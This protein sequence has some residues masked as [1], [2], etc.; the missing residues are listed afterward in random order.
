MRLT[1]PP[2]ELGLRGKGCLMKTNLFR[3][4]IQ[5]AIFLCLLTTRPAGAVGYNLTLGAQGSG[6][7]TPDNVNNPHPPGVVITIT[8][9]ANAGWYFANWS[10]DT[11]GSVNPLAVT[12]NSNLSI[13]GNFLAFPTYALTLVTNGQ[14]TIALS[15]TGGI[16]LSNTVV[17]ATA[18]PATGWVF[19]GWSGGTNTSANPVALTVQTNVGLTGTFAQLPAFDAQP[20]SVTN[21]SGST[22]NYSA[23]AV[24]NAPLRYQWFFSGGSLTTAATNTTLAL[25]NVA[26]GQAGNYW[27]VATN[28]YGS[29]TS[30]VA[31]LTLTNGSTNAVNSPD[32]ASLRAAIKIGGWVSLGFNGTVTIT[33]TINIT[34]NVILDGSA[35]AATISGGNAVRL[36]TVASGVTFALTNVTLANGSCIV[37]SGTPGTA[38]DAGAIYNN[39]GTVMLVGCTLTNNSAQSLI[40]GGLARGGVIFNNGGS[41]SLFQSAISN[42]AAIGGGPNSLVAYVTV[43]TSLGGAFFN[44]NGSML[45][46]GCNVSSNLSKSVCET[47][48]YY[49]GTGLAMGGG[50][51]QASGTMTIAGSIVS[52]NQALGGIGV[53]SSAGSASPAYGGACA[54][55]GSLTIDHSQFVANTAKGGDHGYHNSGASGF[56][57]AVYS[58]A[59]M[60]AS[61][62]SFFGNQTFSGSSSDPHA[63]GLINSYGGGIYNAGTA[64]LSRCLVCSNYVQGGMLIPYAFGVATSFDGL[65]GGIF[66]VSQMSATNCTIALNSAVGGSFPAG[67]GVCTSG[68]A[69]GGGV[70]NNTNATFIGMNLTIASNSCLSPTGVN[71][72]NSLAAGCQTANTSGTLRLHN[73]LLAYGGING[74][75]YGSITDDGYNICSDATGHLLSGA[76]YNNTDPQVAPVANYGG[77]TLSM[78]LLPTSPA[79]DFGDSAG[80]PSADQRGYARPFGAGPDMGA[81]EYGAEPPA[82]IGLMIGAGN[83]QLSYTSWTPGSYR[84]QASTNLTTWTDLI[85][86]GPFANPTYQSQTI[87]MQGFSHRYFRLLVQ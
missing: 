2:P 78:A 55:I 5:F 52:M 63:V 77:P 49:Y 37:T 47:D 50:I 14:G 34:N 73:S 61:D 10:G 53:F 86:N 36:F 42:N 67:N 70:F 68:N 12:M 22:V 11:N 87:G 40:F 16:Y 43:G 76:S 25:T 21:K 51:F 66:N 8:A 69:L 59:A 58:T 44:T 4:G 46:S 9:A 6:T 19:S 75:A 24:G 64:V 26:S 71:L 79:I 85:T 39:G 84:L 80:L 57:G 18:T 62:S 74:N 38:A 17:T 31:S 65:G 15:P 1:N 54:T 13:T 20:I 45:I 3:V 56:G 28:S 82:M 41:V 32:E 83:V 29:A 81:F 7:V 33:N 27:I 30:Q 48:G 72:T 60:F 23:H 35:V